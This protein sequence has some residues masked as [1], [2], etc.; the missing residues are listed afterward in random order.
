MQ[1]LLTESCNL[2]HRIN[3]RLM[4]KL[5][6]IHGRS[7]SIE[8]LLRRGTNLMKRRFATWTGSRGRKNTL[9]NQMASVTN[10]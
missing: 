3:F 7:I 10:I 9:K 2:A 4:S 1:S 8:L 5:E 6:R